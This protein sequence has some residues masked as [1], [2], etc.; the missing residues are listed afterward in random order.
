[1]SLLQY[2]EWGPQSSATKTLL[3][4]LAL[5][6][7]GH[8]AIVIIAARPP[9]IRGSAAGI[10]GGKRSAQHVVVGAVGVVDLVDCRA[11]NITCFEQ[12]GAWR[13]R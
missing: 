11:P 13:P 12:H 6:L 4:T 7:V 3:T 10:M 9:T 8:S 1:L 2:G 5:L